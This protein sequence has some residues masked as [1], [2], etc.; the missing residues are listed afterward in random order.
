MEYI[1]VITTTVSKFNGK[2]TY[3]TKIKDPY[4][5][6]RTIPDSEVFYRDEN[7][8][9]V[10]SMTSIDGIGGRKVLARFPERFTIFFTEYEGFD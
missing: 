5:G 7:H 2:I 10:L 8:V 1:V 3:T 4:N 6:D 9:C